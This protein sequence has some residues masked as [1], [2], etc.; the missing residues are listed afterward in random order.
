[1]T[2]LPNGISQEDIELRLNS[3]EACGSML[4]LD[5][6]N[7]TIHLV[8]RS[9]KEYLVDD[10]MPLSEFHINDIEIKKNLYEVCEKFLNGLE[11][12]G[13]WEVMKTAESGFCSLEPAYGNP[14]WSYDGKKF[15][16]DDPWIS[17]FYNYAFHHCMET[18]F[19]VPHPR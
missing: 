11:W 1:M 15:L 13:S 6:I 14:L 17:M 10:S 8:H 4:Y 19:K 2:T 12:G 7:K 5:D 16:Y 18:Q 3:Y 9:V